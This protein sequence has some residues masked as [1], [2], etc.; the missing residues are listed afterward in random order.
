MTAENIIGF[1]NIPQTI[2]HFCF[3][4]FRR[5][6]KRDAL[7]FKVDNIWH[8]INGVGAIDRIKRIGMGLAALGVK[9]GDRI[10]IISENR[11]EWSFVDLAILSLRAV[12]VP[13]YTTQAVEQIRFILENSGA[14]MLFISGKKLWKHASRAIESVERLEKLI[15]FDADGKPDG[16]TRA[17]SLGEV[18]AQ[19]DA[20]AK[21][22]TDVFENSLAAIDPTDL[23][24]IIYTS[25]TTGEPKGVMLTHEN[26]TSNIVSISKGLP[27]RSTD[28]SLAVLPL[29]H[30]FERTVFY[31]LCANGVSI[32]YC[33]AFD[34]LASQ[35]AEVKPTI[36][37]AVPRLFEQ[38]YH[39][40]VKKGKAAGG[41]KTRLFEWALVVGQE[42][43]EAKD[44]RRSVSSVLAARHAVANR[45]VFSK[46]RAGVGGHLRFFVSGGAPLSKKLGYAFWA[47]GIPILQGYGMTEAC[48]TCANRPDDN[49]VGSI[50]K[51]FEGIEM[52]IADK[53]GEVLIRGKN[54]MRSY[55]DKPDATALAL[56]DDGFYH[57]G[58]VGYEDTD[59]HFYIT[60]RLKDLFK[61]SNGKY[62]A[63]LQVESLLK[64]SPLVSQLVVVGSGRKQVG[65]LIVPD[66]EALK[67]E[68]SADGHDTKR[69]REELCEDPHFIKR[70]QRDAIDLTREL[71]DYE[72][73]KR[74]YLLPREFSID[75]GEMT[76][77]L[78]I[79]RSVIDEKYEEAI[80]EICGS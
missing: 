29:S 40:I 37:T 62:V 25:G 23:A 42:Y 33:A 4:S 60:D 46:W 20:L 61:L 13:I 22:D 48:V 17:I 57:T 71:S 72:R 55:Y 51:P 50:G 2:P 26:F 1:E 39:K 38:V 80:D 78:K 68:M 35:L 9:A 19:G 65:A 74:V 34:Q 8:Y 5:H 27:I 14:K 75:K 3:E 76:P 12:N 77:T 66:W 11:P 31:V 24:T 44:K 30:I 52:K 49:K 41:W 32:H 79:K 63:P 16:E 73:I 67:E 47:A 54:V 64:Q 15:F 21:I 59:G 69:S 56:D 53:D 7:A 6:N 36:M 28:R 45:L 58:D 18:E 10:A 70:M 43:W